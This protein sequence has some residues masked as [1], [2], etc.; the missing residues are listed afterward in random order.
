[1]SQKHV[2][3]VTKNNAVVG[4]EVFAFGAA[5]ELAYHKWCDV[6]RTKPVVTIAHEDVRQL[7][8]NTAQRVAVCLQT[9]RV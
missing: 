7:A 8:L 9:V 5:A 1:M 6:Y 4:Q 2:V 3:V